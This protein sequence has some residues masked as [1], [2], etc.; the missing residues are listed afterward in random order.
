MTNIHAREDFRH[1]SL[2]S[3]VCQCLIAGFGED[4]Y[5]LALEG[6]VNIL[7]REAI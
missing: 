4:S 1:T 7:H 6:L 3:G 5:L 2:L